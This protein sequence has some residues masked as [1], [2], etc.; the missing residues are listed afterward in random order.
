MSKY[1]INVP[2][3]ISALWACNSINNVISIDF[4][5]MVNKTLWS[6][7]LWNCYHS[8]KTYIHLLFLYQSL[9]FN[10]ISKI[11]FYKYESVLN[12]WDDS[13][14]LTFVYIIS[15]NHLKCTVLLVWITKTSECWTLHVLLCD[16]FVFSTHRLN[17]I[18]HGSFW[19]AINNT[20]RYVNYYAVYRL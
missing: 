8:I 11:I 3:L 6:L 2:Y 7:L 17:A 19:H 4:L 12:K 13:S 20:P 14:T 18:W 10:L 5:T 15:C 1:W 9:K 16:Y